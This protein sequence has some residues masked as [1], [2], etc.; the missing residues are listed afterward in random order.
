MEANIWHEGDVMTRAAWNAP[1]ATISTKKKKKID[2]KM[3][4]CGFLWQAF[5]H[6][7]HVENMKRR[8]TLGK[9][10]MW[11][12]KMI[13]LI[14]WLCLSE[15][16]D[17]YLP[18]KGDG[19]RAGSGCYIESIYSFVAMYTCIHVHI[20]NQK[21]LKWPVNRRR[22]SRSGSPLCFLPPRCIYCQD[23]GCLCDWG[24]K[25]KSLIMGWTSGVKTKEN[26][27]TVFVCLR[28]RVLERTQRP[29]INGPSVCGLGV[30]QW[31][32]W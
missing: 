5:I 20:K 29:P 13:S 6:V 21:W 31:L 17:S 27:W 22:S 19:Q 9:I 1:V 14:K 18:A 4:W 24:L 15:Q 26:E 12:R 30:S 3:E 10:R 2:K 23:R 16:R 28:I 7:P 8:I 11:S 25:Q 32:D